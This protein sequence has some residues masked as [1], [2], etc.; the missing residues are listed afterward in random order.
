MPN[1]RL[2][3][4]DL[5]GVLYHA[6]YF[7]LYE[8]AREEFLRHSG[9]PYAELVKNGQHLAVVESQQK[10]LKPIFYGM[11]LQIE[12]TACSV[13]RASISFQYRIFSKDVLL[14]K[15][16]TIHAFIELKGTTFASTRLPDL[17]V[18]ACNKIRVAQ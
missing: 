16:I 11:P 4:F 10:F 6:N 7:H 9:T 2:G 18:E 1:L 13:K 14:H 17:I 12:L 15:A 3:E 5:G 8:M